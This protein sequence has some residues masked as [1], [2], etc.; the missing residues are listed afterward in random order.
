MM[1]VMLGPDTGPMHVAGAMN[2][3]LVVICF[4]IFTDLYEIYENATILSTD[5]FNIKKGLTGVSLKTVLNSV[6]KLATTHKQAPIVTV[7]KTPVMKNKAHA[8][9]RI[10]GIGDLLSSLPG[11]ATARSQNGNS[12]NTYVYITSEVGKK[13]LE[14][15][16]MFDEVIAV[17]YDHGPAGLPLPPGGVDYSK[18]DTISNLI[19]VVDFLPT[20]DRVPRTELFARAIG[21]ERCDY[22]APGW[23]ITVPQEWKDAAWDILKT[24]KVF[25][26]HKVLAFQVDTKGASRGWPKPRAIELCST[27]ARRGWKVVLLSDIEYTGYPRTAVNLTGKLSITEYV[28]IIAICTAGLSPDSALIHIAGAMDVPA[29]GLFGAVAPEL[30]I[31]HYSTIKALVGKASCVPCNDWQKTSCS[32][33]AKKPECM[34]SIRVKDVVKEIDSLVKTARSGGGANV[35]T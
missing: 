5:V 31:A 34:W 24:H 13:L 23:K 16:N 33:K 11:I 8:Y 30:R 20:S 14:C 21:I 17:K 3:P 1:D 4:K 32:H 18:F 19:N 28:G 25:R 7:K 27:M 29:L 12:N 26:N 15:S 6:S 35:G 10:R 9:I 22:D 2:I